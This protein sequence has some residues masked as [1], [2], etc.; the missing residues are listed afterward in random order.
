MLERRFT[1]TSE[2]VQPKRPI[3]LQKWQEAV[4]PLLKFSTQDALVTVELTCGTLIFHED[5]AEAQIL[6]EEL[7]KSKVAIGQKIGI[8]RTDDAERPILIRKI[9]LQE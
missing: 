3:V 4:A 6:N 2:K 5:S 1:E 9:P 8:I 7:G